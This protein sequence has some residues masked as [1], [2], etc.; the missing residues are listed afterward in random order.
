M[1][2]VRGSLF[3]SGVNTG[4]INRLGATRLYGTRPVD[5]GEVSEMFL[6]MAWLIS[7]WR[8]PTHWAIIWFCGFAAR[9]APNWE[10]NVGEND[11][12]TSAGLCRPSAM[13]C[14]QV[15][16]ARMARGKTCPG[17]D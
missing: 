4:K 8:L 16:S 14:F 17:S 7:F 10:R 9:K 6:P 5:R 3:L 1:P 12:Y 11:L 2:W 13:A 15:F